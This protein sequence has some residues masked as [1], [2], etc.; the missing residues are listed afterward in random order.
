LRKPRGKI[1]V[2]ND[3]DEEIVGIFQTVQD[4]E[5]CRML[6]RRLRYTPYARRTFE[7]A[8]QPSTNP[9]IRAQRA[10]VRAYQSFHHEALFN[11]RKTTFADA[12]HRSGTS[13]KAHEWASYPRCLS[14]ISRR[15]QGVVIE[16]RP[17]QEVIRVQDTPDT[18]FFVDPTLCPIRTLKIRLSPRNER[19][20]ARSPA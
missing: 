12:K 19:G 20:R 17:A 13:C 10:I 11:L 2:Y 18:L 7:T 8:F 5:Q 14:S 9:I 3:L 6:M 1:E 15:L 16:C 4:P